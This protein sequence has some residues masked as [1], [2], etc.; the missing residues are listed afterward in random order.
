ML[1]ALAILDKVVSELSERYKVSIS[2]YIAHNK[3]FSGKFRLNRI[4]NDF[5]YV[6]VEWKKVEKI[7]ESGNQSVIYT[8]SWLSNI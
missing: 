4:S 8:M 5:V 6:K 2:T 1:T 3:L 7:K